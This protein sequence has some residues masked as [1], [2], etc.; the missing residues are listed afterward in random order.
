M[1]RAGLSNVQHR[2]EM[3]Q[4]ES[5]SFADMKALRAGHQSDRRDNTAMRHAVQRICLHSKE[6]LVER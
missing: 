3:T 1:K 4:V 6:R 5:P 2:L